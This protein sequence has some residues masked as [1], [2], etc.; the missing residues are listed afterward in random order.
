MILKLSLDALT[1]FS[2]K[3]LV[4]PL[5]AGILGIILGIIAFIVER[6]STSPNVVDMANFIIALLQYFMIA[7]LLISLGVFGF[8]LGKMYEQVK[9]RP[10]YIIEERT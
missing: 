3:P 7:T 8:Y 1:S 5:K 9:G 2:V 4:F 10:R 6:V